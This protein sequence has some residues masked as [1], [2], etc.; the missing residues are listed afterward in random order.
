MQQSEAALGD[1]FTSAQADSASGKANAAHF[2]MSANTPSG[3]VSQFD[4]LYT[5]T[6]GWRAYILKGAPGAASTLLS[7]AGA[8]LESAGIDI[9]YIHCVSDPGSVSALSLPQRKLCIVDGMP[10]HCIKVEF[11]GI[12]EEEVVLFTPDSETL[13]AERARILQFA[14]RAASLYDRVYRFI[15]A[16]VSLKNDTYRIA[17]ECLDTEAVEKY[18]NGLAKRLFSPRI[19]AA[20]GSATSETERFLSGLTANGVTFFYNAVATAYGRVF[21]LEDEYGV[22]RLLISL[23]REKALASGHGVINCKCP[24]TGCPEHLLIPS[25]SIAFVTSNS[26]H[27]AEGRVCRHINIKRFLDCDSLRLKKARIGFNR[28]TARELYDQAISLLV[29]AKADDDIVREC[30]GPAI[31]LKE[32][33]KKLDALVANIIGSAQG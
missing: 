20:G 1:H 3:F 9:E 16:A 10:P 22:G 30:Y 2:F 26:F 17:A 19:N 5:A 18:A 29:E 12:V 33:Q 14:A 21:V 15:S 24:V 32:G 25:L 28:R 27:R 31:D 11:P 13:M 4:K 23:L 7:S 6:A 8:Q